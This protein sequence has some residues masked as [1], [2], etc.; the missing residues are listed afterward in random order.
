M[1][2]HHFLQTGN[3]AR[4]ILRRD[5]FRILVWMFGFWVITIMTAK[6][7]DDL[8]P[9]QA[10]RQQIAPTME[11]PAITAL[12]GRGYGLDQ[13]TVGAMM[14][15]QMLAMT[16]LIIGVMAVLL[17]V[18]HTRTDEEDGRTELIRSLPTGRLAT[19]SATLLVMTGAFVVL[20][21]ITGISLYSLGIESMDMNGSLLYG[22]A[23]SAT[24]FLFSATT[25]LCS[26]LAQSSKGAIGLSFLFLG[27]F[28]LIRAVGDVTNEAIS[29]FSPF[30]WVL[31]SQ[32]YVHNY[33]WHEL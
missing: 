33:W 4:L 7:F 18:R 31:E 8:Y 21:L 14:A 10:E 1:L 30:G 17:V 12:I 28:Y 3:L 27:I 25:A 29:W 2:K 15:H 13:Y 5:R 22:A 23:L 11:N 26:Q 6:A 16:L 19:T 24:G 20:G 32:V 9:T